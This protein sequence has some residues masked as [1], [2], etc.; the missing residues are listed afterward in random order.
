MELAALDMLLGMLSLLGWLALSAC[1]ANDDVPAPAIGGL[2][3]DHGIPGTTV[4]VSGTY[5]CQ[6]PRVDGSDVDPLGCTH[7]G[8]VMFGTA[9]GA[10]SRIR[11]RWRAPRS[12]R[13][14]PVRSR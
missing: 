8:T 3:P 12:L 7:I 10:C 4:A 9:P 14:Q 6:Q 11:T 2:Q 1:S 13:S 5:L